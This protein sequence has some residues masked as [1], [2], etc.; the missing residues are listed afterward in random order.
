MEREKQADNYDN[1]RPVKIPLQDYRFLG[2]FTTIGSGYDN[3]LPFFKKSIS[4]D[5]FP[6]R[7]LTTFFVQPHIFDGAGFILQYLLVKLHAAGVLEIANILAFRNGM[8]G[9]Y[10]I[11]FPFFSIDGIK[12]SGIAD[13]DGL[14]LVFKIF[15]TF[16]DIQTYK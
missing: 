1:I 5:L 8:N 10:P 11:L 14:Y 7:C 12:I 15:E 9:H 16:A 3:P 2:Q 4:R 6:W 13:L